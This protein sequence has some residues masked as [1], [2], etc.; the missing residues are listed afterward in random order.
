MQTK[1]LLKSVLQDTSLFDRLQDMRRTHHLRSWERN[2]RPVPPPHIVKQLAV[3]NT[4]EQTQKQCFIETGTYD[5]DMVYAVKDCFSLIYTIEIFEPLYTKITSRF[6]D[7]PHIHPLLGDSA[8]VLPTVVETLEQSSLF[9]L[10]G[11]FS[12][13]LEGASTGR[14]EKDTPIMEELQCIAAHHI[15]DHAILID[16]ARCFNGSNDYPTLERLEN[17]VGDLFPEH[18]FSITDD[19][20]RIL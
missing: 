3:R 11:H 18:S 12:G 1:H 14:G 9:W 4:A 13:V 10:D 7:Y 6:A 19:I 15:K 16:D 8:E 20:I 2:G 17:L 5:G